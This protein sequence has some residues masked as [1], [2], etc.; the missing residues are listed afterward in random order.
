MLSN[1]T[2]PDV[3]ILLRSL[4]II[5]HGHVGLQGPLL[6]EMSGFSLTAAPLKAKGVK[7]NKSVNK[8][9]NDGVTMQTETYQ[10]IRF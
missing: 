5:I 1:A 10:M 8:K 2:A 4:A 7:K 9:N 3:R 6:V